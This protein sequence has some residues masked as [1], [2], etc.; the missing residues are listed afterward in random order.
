MAHNIDMSNN[1]ANLAFLGSRGAIWHG[2][3]SAMQAGMSLQDWAKAAGLDWT[4]VKVP[5]L[6][7]L[8][9]P[10]F[11]HMPADRRLVDTGLYFNARSD[12]AEV[13]S[14]ALS[15]RHI[16]VQPADVLAWFDKYISV[17]DRFELDTAGS[18]K[19]GSIIWA[20]AKY[21]GDVTV[22]GERHLARVLMSTTFDGTGATINKMSM[23]RVVCNNTLDA[24]LA[25]GKNATVRTRHNT[26]FNAERVGQELSELAQSVVQFKAMGDAMAAHHM[27]GEEIS[28][29]FKLTLDIDPNEAQGDLSTRKLNQFSDLT[30]AYHTSVREGAEKGTAW[31]A[32]QAITRYVDHDRGTRQSEHAGEAKVLSAQFGSGAALK[33][34]AMGLLMPRIKDRVLIDA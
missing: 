13:I 4:A 34:K 2:L 16:N 29:F 24:A 5:A 9:G 15:D 30:R 23:V 26:K 8:E 19:G 33:G 28:A 31:A 32:L 18:L 11:A 7:A 22:A 1:R 17:D 25:G 21:N 3:G 6:A 27:S 10:D 20:M 14:P 12:T